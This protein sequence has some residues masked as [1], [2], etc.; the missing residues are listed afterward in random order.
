[1]PSTRSP[2]TINVP[3]GEKRKHINYLQSFNDA[4]YWCPSTI[5]QLSHPVAPT[6]GEQVADA[7]SLGSALSVSLPVSQNRGASVL[8]YDFS[9]KNPRADS[10]SCLLN[11]SDYPKTMIFSKFA[12]FYDIL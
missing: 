3:L 2:S 7:C 10:L 9:P 11:V 5:R 1:M 12:N 6:G 4:I 8:F